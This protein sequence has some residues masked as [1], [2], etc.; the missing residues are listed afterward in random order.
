MWER[1]ASCASGIRGRKGRYS[2]CAPDVHSPGG[3]D[4]HCYTTAGIKT[5]FM[6]LMGEL[7]LRAQCARRHL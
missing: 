4:F 1:R 5:A 2:P 7:S 6:G 3:E